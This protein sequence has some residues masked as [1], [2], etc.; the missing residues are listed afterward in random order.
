MHTHIAQV[1]EVLFDGTA[2][3]VTVPAIDGEMTVLPHHEPFI[4]T[5]KE[6]SIT[7]RLEDKSEQKFD[8]TKGVLEVSNNKTT[9]LL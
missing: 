8:I 3:A 9:I 6:G 5:L 1:N 4:S 2:E 7:V